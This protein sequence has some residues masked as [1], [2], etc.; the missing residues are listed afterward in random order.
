M[1]ALACCLLTSMPPQDVLPWPAVWCS[2]CCSLQP[3][4][5]H[6]DTLQPPSFGQFAPPSTLRKRSW[7]Q[8]LPRHVQWNVETC[9]FRKASTCVVCHLAP[10]PPWRWPYNEWAVCRASIKTRRRPPPCC[11]RQPRSMWARI[12]PSCFGP[13]PQLAGC[14]LYPAVAPYECWQ[15]H[16]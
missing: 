15:T 12:L 9:T 8:P 3:R 10:S 16:W 11:T 7:L 2:A 1:E 5:Q 6:G 4:G 14:T 13:L